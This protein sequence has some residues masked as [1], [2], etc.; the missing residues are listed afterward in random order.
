M[1]SNSEACCGQ[2]HPESYPMGVVSV[3]PLQK[4]AVFKRKT[5]HAVTGNHKCSGYGE[6]L[7]LIVR[8]IS[9]PTAFRLVTPIPSRPIRA[10]QLLQLHMLRHAER[11]VA[12]I[13]SNKLGLEEDVAPYLERR[14]GGLNASKAS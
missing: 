3:V 6:V 4:T 14:S 8:N 7:C 11:V 13:K 10:E 2:A 9:S 5:R 12:S 1:N